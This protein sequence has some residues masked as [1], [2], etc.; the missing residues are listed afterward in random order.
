MRLVVE[1][2]AATFVVSCTSAPSESIPTALAKPAMVQFDLPV[3]VTVTIDDAAK[4]TTPLQQFELSP[5]VHQVRL[6]A[7]CQSLDST[8]VELVA[9]ETTTIDVGFAK[10]LGTATYVPKARSQDGKPLDV[11]LKL[12]DQDIGTVKH[13]QPVA[14]PACPARVALSHD[15]LGGFIED[16]EFASGKTMTRDVVLAAGTDMVRIQG[17][18]FVRG[19][20][21]PEFKWFTQVLP[22]WETDELSD[23]ADLEDNEPMLPSGAERVP[24]TVKA[25][26][27]DRHEVTAE[28]FV[29]CRAAAKGW[30][31]KSTKEC[32]EFA[33]ASCALR[34]AEGDYVDEN[35]APY[36]TIESDPTH[37]GR[38]K[39]KGTG[40]DRPVNCVSMLKAESYCRWL[41]KRLPTEAE[42]EFAARSRRSDFDQPWGTSDQQMNTNLDY[43]CARTGCV[44][45]ISQP[46]SVCTYSNGNTRQGVCDMMGNVEEFVTRTHLPG[47]SDK[48][49]RHTTRGSARSGGDQYLHRAW[50]S[51]E[52]LGDHPGSGLGGSHI[53]FRCA[54][55]V[56]QEGT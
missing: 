33:H 51:H 49:I 21:E 48:D 7:P 46:V 17:G 4:G 1:T 11:R 26:D 41:G 34:Y 31:C 50:Q 27:I 20:T 30:M 23:F 13:G 29:A 6:K 44:D 47:R 36:C 39:V 56:P 24:M 16:V 18:D 8:P 40:G 12:G 35:D 14:V 22:T 45:T 19:M 37:S 54:R 55:D 10:G 5:G 53:G 25:F 32:A 3:G 9:G 15:G 38:L 43:D 52:E 2:I 42:W 28:Q